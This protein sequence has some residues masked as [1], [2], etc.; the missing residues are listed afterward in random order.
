MLIYKKSL[1]LVAA[2]LALFSFNCLAA[3]QYKVS[4]SLTHND[5][6]FAAPTVVVKNNTPATIETSGPSGYKL[7]LTITDVAPDK[8]RVA[9]TV[10]SQHGNF[11]PTVVVQPGKPATVSV[12]DM[13]ITITVDRAGS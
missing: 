7:S 8:I 2:F 6:A 4:T 11:A 9:T 3:E 13:G 10:E 1:V 12:G 5:K